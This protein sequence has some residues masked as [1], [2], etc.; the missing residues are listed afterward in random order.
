MIIRRGLFPKSSSTNK[1][2]ESNVGRIFDVCVGCFIEVVR[3]GSA[4]KEL[5]QGPVNARWLRKPSVWCYAQVHK[6]LRACRK[7]ERVS[8]QGFSCGESAHR[9]NI[10]RESRDVNEEL[11][12]PEVFLDYRRC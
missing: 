9:R 5:E 12:T 2:D 11:L 3:M 4:T 1:E 7:D 6:S 10:L 8:G